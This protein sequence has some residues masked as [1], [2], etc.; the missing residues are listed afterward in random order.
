MGKNILKQIIDGLTIPLESDSSSED[1]SAKEIEKNI[2]DGINKISLE[3]TEIIIKNEDKWFSTYRLA[4]DEL[5]QKNILFYQH[6]FNCLDLLYYLSLEIGKI[7][8]EQG[9]NVKKESYA[10]EHVL[11]RLHAKSLQITAEM[12][13]LLRGG[14]AD[15][16][17]GRWRS[18][19]E[20]AVIMNCITNSCE[21]IA[22]RF[23]N[24]V[25]VE[26]AKKMELYNK[27]APKHFERYSQEHLDS[28]II[29]AKKI[30]D[31]FGK[32]FNDDYGWANTLFP[33]RGKKRVT[34]DDIADAFSMNTLKMHYKWACEKIHVTTNSLYRSIS[35]N[36]ENIMMAGASDNGFQDPVALLTISLDQINTFMCIFLSKLDSMDPTALVL[37]KTFHSLCT[38]T[39]LAFINLQEQ[40]DKNYHEN[41]IVFE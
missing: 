32:G 7:F 1:V 20:C 14:F 12:I 35:N 3:L 18:L 17:L 29:Q 2:L 5:S 11:F 16:A 39:E 6:G 28:V 26:R 22:I 24:H 4:N 8:Q 23:L 34:F 30:V 40:K 36:N 13:C 15:G 10:R 31:Y 33:N 37:Q 25:E 41:G 21:D 27:Y 19:H 9:E 38:K